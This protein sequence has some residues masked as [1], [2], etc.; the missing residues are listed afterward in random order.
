MHYLILNT[1]VVNGATAQWHNWDFNSVVEFRG[2]I[3]GAK[4][5]GIFV[6][7]NSATDNG[8][9]IDSIVRTPI[10][11][12]HT[13]NQKHVRYVYLKGEG[14]GDMKLIIR[15]DEENEQERESSMADQVQ[16]SYRIPVG[17]GAADGTGKGRHFDFEI[18]NVNGSDFSIDTL[19]AT[20][21][22][23]ARKP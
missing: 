5:N 21:I 2:K 14:D 8:T 20:V 19:E 12:F 3:I 10:I 4:D 15:D 17:R 13:P 1:N 7:D 11:D 16:K 9:D 18:Q 23:V 22:V 6:I